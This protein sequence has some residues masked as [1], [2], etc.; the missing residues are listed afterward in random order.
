MSLRKKQPPVPL[1]PQG[2]ADFVFETFGGRVAFEASDTA[3]TPYGGLAP[4]AAFLKR[5]GFVDDLVR[6]CPVVR[7]S[8][9][10]APV[11][12]IVVSLILLNICDGRRF[13]HVARLCEDPA[14]AELF[15]IRAVRSEDTLRRFLA[16]I[17]REKLR[18]WIDGAAV[19]I[20]K[21]LPEKI[22]NDWDSTV[23]TRY[24]SQEKAAVGY[25][26][27]K[28][29]RPSHHPLLSVAAGTRIATHYRMRAG[30]TVS[31]TEWNEAM[32][33]CLSWL[34]E[35]RIAVNRGDIGFGQES[36]MAWHEA[37]PGAPAFLF[38]LK[39][40]KNV[41]RQAMMLDDADWKGPDK[42]GSW[43]VAEAYVTLP[44]WTKGRRVVFARRI[45]HTPAGDQPSLW[46]ELKHE[47]DAYVTDLPVNEVNAWQIVLMYRDRG[48]AENL[49]DELKN[50][51][52]L[53]GF[54]SS[55]AG[56]TEG[57]ARFTLASAALW[58]LFM[59]LM[60]PDRH[61]EAP[62][63]RRWCLLMASRLVKSG[64]QK[65]LQVCVN[66]DWWEWL[67]SGYERLREWL[68]QTA[69]QLPYTKRIAPI[70]PALNCGI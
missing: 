31:A 9:N 2:E 40:T 57:A 52:G 61:V 3:M 29:G 41:M 66:G 20:R 6:T 5:L 8:G 50:Q 68:R 44:S 47:Y 30:N 55:D 42:L 59:R 35:G 70:Q 49:F 28:P 17:P 43:Q 33:D 27:T 21:L 38:K 46:P 14:M 65:T 22:I 34:G 67:K 54:C 13:A 64:R 15:G 69:P 56:V 60:E 26:P 39:L 36:V 48:D 25:N 19:C 63:G 7:T 11:R 16:S 24:G 32:E 62:T 4:F 51:W 37:R 12:D 10:A 18:P 45:Q 23:I 58:N 53:G 1:H